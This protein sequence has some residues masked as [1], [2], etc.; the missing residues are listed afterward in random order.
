MSLPQVLERGDDVLSDLPRRSVWWNWAS[1]ATCM[2]VVGFSKTVLNLFY[3][4]HL[5]GLENLDRALSKARE[6]NRGLVT[7]MNHMSVV[8]DPFMWGFLPWRFFTDLDDIRWGLAASN[9]CFANKAS[10]YFFSLGKIFGTERLGGSPFQGCID[11]AIRVMSPD[12]TLDLIYDGSSATDKVWLN[13]KE[14]FH[15]VKQNYLSPMIRSKPSWLHVFPEGFV[16]QLQAPF[17]N[18]MRYF[19]WGITRI[20][21]ES[22]RQPVIVPMFAHGFEKIAP[23]AEDGGVMNRFLPSNIGAEVHMYISKAIDDEVIHK[24]REEWLALVKKYGDGK[25]LTQEL[26]FGE[27]AQELRSRLANELR[28]QVA[29]IRREIGFPEEDTRFSD[30]KWWRQFTKTEGKSDP[31]VR[32]NGLNWAIRRLHGLPEKDD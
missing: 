12:D 16:L 28:Q 1:Q 11:A 10:S 27:K 13:E 7:V 23:E 19:H 14:V 20:I 26:R 32:F 2:A 22:T 29:R 24:Y 3:E 4:P 21:L 6:E 25:D 30:P 15:K 18:S 31:E 8:D 5:H 17:A 9:L